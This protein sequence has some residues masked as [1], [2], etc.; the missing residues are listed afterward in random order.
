M[1]DKD[2]KTALDAMRR[3]DEAGLAWF[4]RRYTAYVS[5][6]VWNLAGRAMTTQDAEEVTADVFLTL[7]RYC[8]RP[9]DGTVKG[10]LGAI[11]RTK[12]LDRLKALG[13]APALEYDALELTAEGPEGEILARE[14]RDALRRLIEAMGSADREIFIRHYYYGESCPDVAA[15]MGMTPAGVRKRLERGRE[16]LRRELE[17]GAGDDDD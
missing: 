6:I 2:E 5:A 16:A 14:A 9:G 4:I 11:A 7:W 10:Y 1:T 17:K 15:A 8:R 3:G 12:A 13:R